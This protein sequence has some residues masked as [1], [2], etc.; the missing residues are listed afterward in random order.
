[1]VVITDDS[2]GAPVI[3]LFSTVLASTAAGGIC[4]MLVMLRLLSIVV[5]LVVIDNNTDYNCCIVSVYSVIQETSG[6]RYGCKLVALPKSVQCTRVISGEQVEDLI[7]LIFNPFE[8][9]VVISA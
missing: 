1:M 2:C 3:S 4:D 6:K 9:L 8:Y 7:V 5:G